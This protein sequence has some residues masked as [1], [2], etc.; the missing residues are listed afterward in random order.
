MVVFLV[1]VGV[2][3]VDVGGNVLIVWLFGKDVDPYM[4]AMHLFFGVGALAAPLLVLWVTA[5]TGG[6]RWVYWILAGLAVPVLV[7]AIRIPSPGRVEEKAAAAG[8]TPMRRYGLVI[9]M[10]AGLLITAA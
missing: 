7:W 3:V 6:I 8:T 9:V 1:G 5:A 2:G 4:N 10:L